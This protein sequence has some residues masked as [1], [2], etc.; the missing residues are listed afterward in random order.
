MQVTS[1]AED[2]QRERQ[3]HA[4][5]STFAPREACDSQEI[6]MSERHRSAQP[7]RARFAATQIANSGGLWTLFVIPAESGPN[8]ETRRAQNK[9]LLEPRKGASLHNQKEVAGAQAQAA[10]L[11]D[12][13]SEHVLQLVS[14]LQLITLGLV[15]SWD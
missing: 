11:F 8:R 1:N 2:L 13:Q 5:T 14:V 10:S 6:A 7:F 3:P 12:D 15:A 9:Q 4:S